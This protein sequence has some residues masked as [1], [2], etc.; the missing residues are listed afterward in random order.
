MSTTSAVFAGEFHVWVAD[1][2][3]SRE[4]IGSTKRLFLGAKPTSNLLLPRIMNR[5]FVSG[6]VVRSR[7]YRVARLSRARIDSLALVWTSLA[8]E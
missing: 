1:S 8:V 4:G 6:Q 7:E 5:I 3:V 2:V